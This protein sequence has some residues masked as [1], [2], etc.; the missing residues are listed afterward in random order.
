[1]ALEKQPRK[2]VLVV[3]DREDV[4]TALELIMK[5]AGFEVIPADSVESVLDIWSE[6]AAEIDLLLSDYSLSE[7]GPTGK[8]LADR[9]VAERPALRFIIV[10]AFRINLQELGLR[11]GVNFFQKP[12]DTGELI[13][14]ARRLVYENENRPG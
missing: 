8:Q 13:A 2:T 6:R 12:F 10:T 14:A 9:L 11:P 5:H 7:D 1:M 3:D 4:L